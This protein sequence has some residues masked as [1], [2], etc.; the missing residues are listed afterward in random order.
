MDKIEW[1][2]VQ[3]TVSNSVEESVT[4]GE[5]AHLKLAAIHV[6]LLFIVTCIMRPR[7]VL[8]KGN[9]DTQ[10]EQTSYIRVMLV[11]SLVAFT[12]YYW[13]FLVLR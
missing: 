11:S 6:V 12:A 13:P 9:D 5:F 8:S 1:A 7:F 4:L 3:S 10:T 2:S